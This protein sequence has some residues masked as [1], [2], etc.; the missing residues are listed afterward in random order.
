MFYVM[1]DL[2]RQRFDSY[3]VQKNLEGICQDPCGN[4]EGIRKEYGGNIAGILSPSWRY[5]AGDE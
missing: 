1:I 4:L 3:T 5:F 2:F